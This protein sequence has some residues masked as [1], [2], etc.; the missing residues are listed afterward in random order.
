MPGFQARVEELGPPGRDVD[1]QSGGLLQEQAESTAERTA[2]T[3]SAR[4]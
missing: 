1:F 3:A 4:S 2:Q